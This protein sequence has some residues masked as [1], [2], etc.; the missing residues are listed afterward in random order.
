MQPRGWDGAEA[1]EV[2]QAPG[3]RVPCLLLAIIE[4]FLHLRFRLRQD[5]HVD[6]PFLSP[7]RGLA[8]Y[9]PGNEVRCYSMPRGSGVPGDSRKCLDGC[10]EIA[11]VKMRR[12]HLI[13]AV[14]AELWFCGRR[15]R[16]AGPV[17]T[18]RKN[19]VLRLHPCMHRRTLQ[20]KALL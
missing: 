4:N 2:E 20:A 12:R 17:R 5:R 16:Q 6:L 8:H 7:E 11:T 3:C 13:G 15:Q 1:D 18:L 19:H 9:C 14:S 10:I